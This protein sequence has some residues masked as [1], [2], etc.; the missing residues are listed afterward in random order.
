LKFPQ[1]SSLLCHTTPPFSLLSHLPIVILPATFFSP[2]SFSV[3]QPAKPPQEIPASPTSG[4]IFLH[5]SMS[6]FRVSSVVTR[7]AT[8]FGLITL[9]LVSS[10]HLFSQFL[11][12]FSRNLS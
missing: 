9:T 4:K 5:F 10:H 3:N 6:L 2:S 12:P 1:K 8:F 11:N 7:P